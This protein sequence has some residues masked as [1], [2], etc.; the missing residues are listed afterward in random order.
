M[1]AGFSL[2]SHSSGTQVPLFYVLSDG[3]GSGSAKEHP[4]DKPRKAVKNIK[5]MNFGVRCWLHSLVSN[6]DLGPV[7]LPVSVSSPLI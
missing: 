4:E 1:W 3:I 5:R 6:C 7:A 2:R